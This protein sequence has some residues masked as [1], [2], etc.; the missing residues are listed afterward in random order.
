MKKP[1]AHCCK[2]NLRG[3]TCKRV[4]EGDCEKYNEFVENMKVYNE[5]LNK[6]RNEDMILNHISTYC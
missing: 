1:V 2:C 4:T 5:I 3:E 6:N